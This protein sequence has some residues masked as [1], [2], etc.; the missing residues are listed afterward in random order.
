MSLCI[1]FLVGS[2]LWQEFLSFPLLDSMHVLAIWLNSFNDRDLYLTEC[3][4]EFCGTVVSVVCFQYSY[5]FV[6]DEN[7]KW[8]N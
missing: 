5:M 2:Y 1:A 3:C 4:G 6:F 8:N 7:V